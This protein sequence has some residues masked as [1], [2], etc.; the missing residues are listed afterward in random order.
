[1]KG[2]EESKYIYKLSQNEKL[3]Y[4]FETNGKSKVSKGTLKTSKLNIDLI[5][6]LI[7]RA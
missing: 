2:K 1:M 6:L 5:S 4:K 3:L 7:M